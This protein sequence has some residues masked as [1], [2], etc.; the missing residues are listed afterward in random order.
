M[1]PTV[2][3]WWVEPRFAAKSPEEG[4]PTDRPAPG[5]EEQELDEG[6]RRGLRAGVLAVVVTLVV[7]VAATWIPGAPLHGMDGR[8]PRWV[9]AIVPLLFLGF[10]IP[11][12][13]YGLA[14]RSLRSDRDA[15]RSDFARVRQLRD[16]MQS[17]CPSG[18]VLR[19]LSMGMSGDY[20]IAIEEGATIVRV[21]SALFEG[22]GA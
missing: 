7:L 9:A 22:V 6:E 10:L 19:H 8:F 21:G 14:S 17:E 3:A 2:T 15:A 5:A 1:P 20:T 11:G 18:V 16:R 12:L 4:G 13:A